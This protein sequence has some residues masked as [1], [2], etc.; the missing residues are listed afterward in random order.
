MTVG[1][2]FLPFAA[3]SGSNVEAQNDY[4]G[5]GHQITGFV[6][7][8]A[9]SAQFNKTF[10]QATLGTA[11]LTTYI[12][13]VLQSY[14]TDDGNLPKLTAWLWQ[15]LLGGG[16]F[17]DTGSANHLSVPAPGSLTFLAPIAGITIRIKVAATNVDG[18]VYL[19]WCGTGELLVYMMDDTPLLSGDIATGEILELTFD[20]AGHWRVVGLPLSALYRRL[21]GG[22]SPVPL[23]GQPTILITPGAGTWTAPRAG[24]VVIEAWGGGGG[25]AAP[26]IGQ[27]VA[28]GGAGGYFQKV[29][30]VFNA[31]AFAYVIGAGGVAAAYGSTGGTG[32]TTSW[33]G[34]LQIATGG[35]G[36]DM[37]N[38][39][40]G[41]TGI[42]G[43]FTLTGGSGFATVTSDT[44]GGWGGTAPRGGAGGNTGTTATGT[45]G[46]LPGG[47]AGGG[48]GISGPGTPIPGPNGL[49]GAAGGGGL[50]VI[51]YLTMF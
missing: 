8:E 4:A 44:T 28:G 46:F 16:Y 17:V 32:G 3:A 41:G 29:H 45:A 9:Q 25:T 40:G 1:T 48:K 39:G 24:I 19:N 12:T 35:S 33:A 21:G 27:A 50:I 18:A 38:P 23:V 13:N 49:A 31:Q 22:N 30:G 14:V 6:S 43:D 15:A 51:R 2:D 26:G 36:G 10:R 5:S 47:G 20:G 37:F 11:A 42:G 7:G 34:G